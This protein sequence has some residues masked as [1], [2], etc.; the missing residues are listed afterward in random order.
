[1]TSGT[2]QP[3]AGLRVLVPRRTEGP[4]P[5]VIATAAAGAE[6]TVVELIATVPPADV[7]EL[8]DLLMA[9]GIGY[10]AW[11]G[12]TSAAVVPVLAARARDAGSDLA[13]LTSQT[14]VAAVG[15]STAS[16]LEAAGVR[17]DL[18]PRGQSSA[19]ALLEA[20]PDGA[21]RVL[22][23][24][25]DLATSTLAT[26]LRGR[27]WHVDDVVAYRTVAGPPVD[28]AVASAYAAGEINAVLLTSGSTARH[29][30]DALGAPP[31]GTIVCCIGPGTA[32]VVRSVGL[33]V[34]AVA[35]EQTPSGLVDALV[36]AVERARAGVPPPPFPYEPP[37]RD[38]PGPDT[39][40]FH[41]IRR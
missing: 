7:T 12:I 39:P 4:D 34:D 21:G 25:G 15:R 19:A 27:G 40:P 32:D 17:V 1:V 30:V 22:L 29:L 8:D 26:G 14:R 33:R 5:L 37:P 3:L 20:W 11:L 9:L 13:A 2:G 28:P 18:V 23:P 6:P 31:P 24:L 16:A 35:A 10:Y 36:G 41:P 38:P